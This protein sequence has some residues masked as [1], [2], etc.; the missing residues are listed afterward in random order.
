MRKA[1]IKAV[2]SIDGLAY[3]D[4]IHI[5][6][7]NL[8]IY[9]SMVIGYLRQAHYKLRMRRSLSVDEWQAHIIHAV[10]GALRYREREQMIMAMALAMTLITTVHGGTWGLQ[11]AFEQVQ[12]SALR[13]VQV[14]K[15]ERRVRR[16]VPSDMIR[17]IPVWVKLPDAVIAGY[18][19]PAEA[20]ERMRMT[21]YSEVWGIEFAHRISDVNGIL[22][23]LEGVMPIIWR[24]DGDLTLIAPLEGL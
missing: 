20:A 18:N 15:A 7:L 2:C 17:R 22:L 13:R 9:E 23:R 16:L 5:A 6:R 1:V 19:V 11:R 10:D 21:G 3:P 12:R 24:M 14:K 4:A 8:S